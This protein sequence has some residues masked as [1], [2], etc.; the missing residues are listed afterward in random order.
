MS[1]N[2][3]NQMGNILFVAIFMLAL[4]AGFVRTVFFPKDINYYENRYCNKIVEPSARNLLDGTFQNS[5]EDA[6]TDQV[7]GAQT[8]KK[9]YNQV[10]SSLSDL[11]IEAMIKSHRDT[12]IHCKN[13]TKIFNGYYTYATYEFET[14]KEAFVSKAN[15]YNA[16]FDSYPDL[17]FYVY[18]IEKDT[19]IN[20]E[21]G[22]K[23]D[24]DEYLFSM[25]NLD[26]SRKKTFEINNFQEFSDYFYKTDHH[27]KHT[28]SY[29][30]YTEVAA[31]LGCE[32]ALIEKGPEVL[33]S[34]SY[35]GSKGKSAASEL[36]KDQFYA[37]QFDFPAFRQID[38]AQGED[39]GRQ[40]DWE[41]TLY[42]EITYGIF[43]G[44]D[45][46]RVVFNTGNTAR[47]NILIIGESFDNAIVKLLATHF[48]KTHCIDLRN[49][50]PHTGSVFHFG[51]YVQENH[52]DKVLFIGNVDFYAMN[53]FEL[54]N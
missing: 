17:D 35:V 52:I 37:Y 23:I 9:F 5:I 12:Y 48:N 46:G 10:N 47:E 40:T 2:K 3:K 43:Y 11:A 42:D 54:E 25:L 32:G 15:N 31:L 38:G 24:A 16:L 14:L 44:G 36:I 6:L 22:E 7:L 50:E 18:F 19:D 51:E 29:K 45:N 34:Q 26:E 49:Y 4:L 1:A 41:P 20:F 27:W 13:G 33:I 39:Y 30:G 28:G 8:L 53:T 21:T